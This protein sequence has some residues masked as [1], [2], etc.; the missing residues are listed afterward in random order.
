MSSLWE[1]LRKAIGFEVR[2]LILHQEQQTA[3]TFHI[4]PLGFMSIRSTLK[5]QLRPNVIQLWNV[6]FVRRFS[7]LEA[8]PKTTRRDFILKTLN[9]NVTTKV[10]IRDSYWKW[11]RSQI[12]YCEHLN[13]IM[14]FSR[15]EI[16]HVPPYRSLSVHVLLLRTRLQRQDFD[17]GTWEGK[18]I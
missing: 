6:H 7:L 4:P 16:S 5:T 9:S 8:R 3:F 12:F 15:V 2:K 11:V 14:G 13:I 1:T 10:V 18:K 17:V